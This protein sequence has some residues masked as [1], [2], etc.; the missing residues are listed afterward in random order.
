MAAYTIR[1][2]IFRAHRL[3]GAAAANA[4]LNATQASQ[5]LEV[6]K[7]VLDV[8]NASPMMLFSNEMYQFTFVAGQSSY[9]VGPGA[10]WVMPVRPIRIDG[11]WVRDLTQ[12]PPNDISMF[13][14]SVN[15]FQSIPSKGSTS[16]SPY[17]FNYD[18]GFPMGTI[19]VY[20]KPS[21]TTHAMRLNVQNHVSETITLNTVVSY[22]PAYRQALIY[23]LAVCLCPE[24]GIE[25]PP[26]IAQIALAT[27]HS[28]MNN[29]FESEAM[30]FDFMGGGKFD[31]MSGYPVTGN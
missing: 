27:K 7:E 23:N 2:L 1:D 5:G 15:D 31:I 17:Y 12:T 14:L 16:N 19:E 8:F 4:T 21:D 18:P 13:E 6:L 22:P 10:D 25:P 28:I 9:T 24:Y 29:N 30:S 20:P 11:A 3:I 26:S